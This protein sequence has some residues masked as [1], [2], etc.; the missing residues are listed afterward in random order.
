RAGVAVT[1]DQPDSAG[2][3]EVLIASS[4]PALGPLIAGPGPEPGTFHVEPMAATLRTGDSGF[5]TEQSELVISGRLGNDLKVSGRRV[6]FHRFVDEVEEVPGVR[7][8]VVVDWQGPQ[9]FISVAE[10]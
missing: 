9:A 5:L 1:I 3:G 10:P 4:T 7:Q 6:S 2:R 8:C